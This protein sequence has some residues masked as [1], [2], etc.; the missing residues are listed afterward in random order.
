[1][2]KSVILSGLTTL[3]AGWLIQKKLNDIKPD[4][5]K[6]SQ[7]VLLFQFPY[8][9][10]C[11]KAQYILDFKR[12][13]YEVVNLL[14]MLHNRFTRQQSEQSKVPYIQHQDQ[15]VA[16]STAIA[17]YLEHH[18]LDNPLL[19][20]DAKQRQA[21]LI[22]EDWLDE[23]FVSALSQY[24]YL[25]NALNPQHLIQDESLNTGVAWIDQNKAKI[26]PLMLKR[27]LRKKGLSL[28]DLPRLESRVSEVLEHALELV[29]TP[30]LVGESLTLADVTLAAHLSV[31]KRLPTWSSDPL[32]QPLLTWQDRVV[33]QIQNPQ[34]I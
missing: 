11:I 22:L 33:H 25:S 24:V 21:V 26:I 1:M 7:E 10:F 12:I 32:Y 5:P 34:A 14:P 20:Q 3:G 28:S 27:T 6:V 4:I 9:P 31:F 23:A 2:R 30:F 29:Q 19:P 13:P 16:D 18:F 8:S 17:L 15:I